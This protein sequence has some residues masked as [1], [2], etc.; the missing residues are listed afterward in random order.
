MIIATPQ[1]NSR[2]S[3]GGSFGGGSLVSPKGVYDG[4]G[5]YEG[6]SCVNI[7]D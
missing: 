5:G 1:R 7:V 4:I 3:Y 6:G 2:Q